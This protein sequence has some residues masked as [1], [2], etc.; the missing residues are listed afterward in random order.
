MEAIEL[1]HYWTGDPTPCMGYFADVMAHCKVEMSGCVVGN[2]IKMHK[3]KEGVYNKKDKQ[4][5][6]KKV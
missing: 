4:G 1:E 3:T 6:P 2:D 5:L